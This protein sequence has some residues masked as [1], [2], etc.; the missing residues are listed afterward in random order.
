MRF[1]YFLTYY[2][3]RIHFIVNIRPVE[4]CKRPVRGFECGLVSGLSQTFVFNSYD[5][6]L[7]HAIV[8]H[9]PF[10]SK[11]NWTGNPFTGVSPSFLQRAFSAGLYFPLEDLFRSSVYNNYAAAGV[12]VGLVGGIFTTPFNSVKY[13]M[14]SSSTSTT[15][16]ETAS[17]L[18]RNG[19]VSRLMRGALPTLYRDM[20]FGITYS[21]LRH[22]GDNGFVINV[23]AAFVATAVSSPFNFARMKVYSPDVAD[24]PLSTAAILRALSSDV[25]S[26]G[27]SIGS[28]AKFLFRRLNVGWGALRVG[29]GMGLGSQIYNSC[30][31]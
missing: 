17:R 19:G 9:R 31:G 6:A 30:C 1:R 25:Q 29:L 8:N 18:V 16:V 12:F 10:L 2:F 11:S 20:T 28:R 5:R 13:A 3:L 26:S 15:L 22:Q 14:W 21:F 27:D 7:Y 24:R 4:K 23:A